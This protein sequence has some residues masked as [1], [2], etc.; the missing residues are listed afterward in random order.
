MIDLTVN[1]IRRLINVLLIRPTHSVAYRLR[2]S[3]WRRRHQARANELR[4]TLELQP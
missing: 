2:C 4:L 1:E 3:H